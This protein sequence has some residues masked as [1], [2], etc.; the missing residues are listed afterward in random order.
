M[1]KVYWIFA[2]SNFDKMCSHVNCV[3]GENL[4][5]ANTTFYSQSHR[6]TE[7]LRIG[8]KIL[9]TELS[10]AQI[11]IRCHFQ[12]V[13]GQYLHGHRL[14]KLHSIKCFKASQRLYEIV[15]ECNRLLFYLQTISAS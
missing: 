7:Y 13:C 14:G 2:E 1:Y 10:S 9:I 5:I 3:S 4:N 11:P 15:S 8:V 12:L 6:R